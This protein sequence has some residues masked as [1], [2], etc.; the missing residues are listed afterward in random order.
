MANNK[1]FRNLS[2]AGLLCVAAAATQAQ[3]DYSFYGVLDLSYGRFEPAG[4]VSEDR[5]NS[6]SLSATF[7][8]VNLKHGFDGGWTPGITLE[9]FIRF[10]DY[11]FGRNDDDPFLS[12]NAYVSLDSN[13]GSLRLGRQQT[14]L[15]NATVN[16]NALGNSVFSPAI[17][18]VFGS[19]GLEGVQG[20]FYWDQAIGYLSPKWEGFS[21]NAMYAWGD[22]DEKGK[23]TG[24]TLTYSQG[25]FAAEVSGQTVRIDRGFGDPTDEDTWQIGATYNFGVAK[26]FGLYT[27]IDDKGFDVRSKIGTAGVSIPLGPGSLLLQAGQTNASG[28]AVDRKHTIVSAAYVYEFD[29]LIDFYIIGQNDRIS[30]LTSGLSVF[31]GAR[32]KF[33]LP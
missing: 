2:L 3:T 8:G 9:T 15:F 5:F 31:A 14:Y 4:Q 12:R 18:S 27:Y 6:N 21:L 24:A 26:V 33:S 23:Y 17:R 13:Y 16:F 28:P 30:G 20:D 25:L 22:S 19:G 29:S 10:Q 11:R 7:I 1:R 32:L